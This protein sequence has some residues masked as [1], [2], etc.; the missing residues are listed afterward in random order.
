LLESNPVGA[1][2][3]TLVDGQGLSTD[4]AVDDVSKAFGVSRATAMRRLADQRE[5]IRTIEKVQRDG[6]RDE[7]Q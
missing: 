3:Q 1:M 4:I 7:S 2:M 6:A 5:S